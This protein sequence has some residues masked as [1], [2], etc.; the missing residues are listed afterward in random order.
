MKSYLV[1]IHNY[2][3]VPM[4]IVDIEPLKVKKITDEQRALLCKYSS[5]KPIARR[6]AIEQVR[7][8]PNQQHF[9]ED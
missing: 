3:F 7:Q 6:Q 4:E 5:L 9:E 2:A 8:N 1:M